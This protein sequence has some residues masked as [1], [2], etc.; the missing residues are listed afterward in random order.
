MMQRIANFLHLHTQNFCENAHRKRSTEKDNCRDNS[1]NS[2]HNVFAEI[3]RQ[4]APKYTRVE[5][6]EII[7]CFKASNE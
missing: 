6:I 3:P 1:M 7:L 5:F 2:F 4:R